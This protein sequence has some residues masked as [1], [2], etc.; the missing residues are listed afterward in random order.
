MAEK[1]KVIIRRCADYADRGRIRALIR[2][3]IAELGEKPHGKVLLK[4]NL[5]FAHSRYGRFG[6]TEPRIMDAIIDVL[7]A[8]PEVEKITIGERTAVT[9]PTRYVFYGAGYGPLAKKPKVELCFFDE[10]RLKE[11][12]LKKGVLHK[13]LMLAE[14]L[15]DADY[16]VWAPKLKHHASARMTHALKLNIGILNADERLL[17]HDWRLEEKIADLYEAGYPDLV[18]SDSILIG[19][20]GELVPKPLHL[21]VLMM[22]NNGVAIDS[23]GARILGFEPDQ[24]E[25]LRIARARGWEP[26][27]DDQIEIVGD[28]GLDELRGRTKNFDRTFNDPRTVETPVRF[29]IGP[30]PGGPEICD[31][32]CVNMIKTSLAVMDA[33]SPGALKN[34]APVA[35]VIGEYEGDVDGQGHPILLVGDCTKVRGKVTGKTRRIGGC[36]TVVPVFMNFGAH[37]FKVPNPYLDPGELVN[38]PYHMM[39]SWVEKIRNRGLWDAKFFS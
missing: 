9:V 11:V 31:T 22:S 27:S 6:Y 37:Y 12:P 16:K 1:F 15:A 5:I 26:V 10:A 29:F 39:R 28:V 3:G 23:V 18:V 33:Y 25:H 2:E 30:R 21:G 4:P 17:Y 38:M 32:G 20:Q 14:A 7:G 34:A 13:S 35:V 36:P 8:I 24:I 19:Q